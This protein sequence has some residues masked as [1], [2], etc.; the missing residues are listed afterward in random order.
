MNFCFGFAHFHVT[1][2]ELRHKNLSSSIV[3]KTLK[4]PKKWCHSKLIKTKTDQFNDTMDTS[5]TAPSMI[6]NL[7][8]YQH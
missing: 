5:Q 8:L 2:P 7:T 4:K 6:P 3:G 1:E